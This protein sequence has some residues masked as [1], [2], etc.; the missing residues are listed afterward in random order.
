MDYSLELERS[1]INRIISKYAYNY[2]SPVSLAKQSLNKL[3]RHRKLYSYEF[4]SFKDTD[5]NMHSVNILTDQPYNSLS[6]E[7]NSSFL[8]KEHAHHS[9]QHIFTFQTIREAMVANPDLAYVKYMDSSV[10][11]N[12]KPSKGRAKRVISSDP[13]KALNHL[14][15]LK[16]IHSPSK[17]PEIFTISSHRAMAHPY[18]SPEDRSKFSKLS[19]A[20]QKDLSVHGDTE[21][22]KEIR[23]LDRKIK[24]FIPGAIKRNYQKNFPQGPSKHSR[25][26]HVVLPKY[27]KNNYFND[28]KATRNFNNDE[29]TSVRGWEKSSPLDMNDS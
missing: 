10:D 12:I 29:E 27:S 25:V 21:N 15:S 23:T 20:D 24:G 8:Y 9:S 4:D 2:T 5:T 6:Q 11:K 17:R 18:R 16:K 3:T 28:P 13:E 26:L 1:R 7:R 14:P 19:E 22:L